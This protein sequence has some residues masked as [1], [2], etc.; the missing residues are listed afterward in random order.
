MALM[1]ASIPI[2]PGKT[3]ERKRWMTELNGP[4]RREFV[5]SRQ[6]FEHPD[7]SASTDD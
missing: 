3:E 6:R 1:A 7:E 2:S 4:R 5:A